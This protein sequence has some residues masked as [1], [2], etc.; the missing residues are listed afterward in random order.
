MRAVVLSRS[1]FSGAGPSPDF[2][3]AAMVGRPG[4]PTGNIAF[5][6]YLFI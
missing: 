3:V 2:T 4:A 6:L 1:G 5:S